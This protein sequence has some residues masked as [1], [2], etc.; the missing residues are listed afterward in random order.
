MYRSSE[1]TR[2]YT[3]EIVIG[4]IQLQSRMRMHTEQ[5]H[6]FIH[7]RLARL[8]HSHAHD[9]H[10]NADVYDDDMRMS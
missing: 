2:T 1:S 7:N 6:S 3:N 10:T 9:T 5:I 8:V 4:H